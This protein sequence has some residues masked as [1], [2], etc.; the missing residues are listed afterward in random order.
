ME[1]SAATR[2]VEVHV[3]L[4]I[5][6][7]D[8]IESEGPDSHTSTGSAKRR[9]RTRVDAHVVVARVDHQVCPRVEFD[10]RAEARVPAQVG[11]R[12]GLPE[13]LREARAELECEVRKL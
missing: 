2:N 10:S 7:D 1:E 13:R 3:A 5:Q 6:V 11:P 12:A 9:Q 8:R 4:R